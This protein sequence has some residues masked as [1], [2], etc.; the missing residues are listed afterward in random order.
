MR[1]WLIV[2]FRDP[3]LVGCFPICSECYSGSYFEVKEEHQDFLST[4]LKKSCFIHD[5]TIYELSTDE[6]RKRRGE[7][8]GKLLTSFLE[9][10]GLPPHPLFDAN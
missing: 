1:P 5:E 8:A 3:G 2:D 10:S 7:L 6:I 4:G 9:Y